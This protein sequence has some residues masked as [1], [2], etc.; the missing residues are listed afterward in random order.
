MDISE[1][2][3]CVKCKKKTDNIDIKTIQTE[4]NKYRL[5]AKCK[6]CN[7]NKSQFIKNLFQSSAKQNPSIVTKKKKTLRFF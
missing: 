4:N 6:I 7:S 5:S 2:V 3:Y 1:R